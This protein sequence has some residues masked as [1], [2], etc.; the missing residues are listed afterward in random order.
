MT[1]MRI[2]WKTLLRFCQVSGFHKLAA[3]YEAKPVGDLPDTYFID[4]GAKILAVAHFD[5]VWWGKGPA[6]AKLLKDDGEVIGINSI[7]LDDRLGAY[8]ICEMLPKLGINVDVLITTDE[9]I[10]RSTAKQVKLNRKYNWICSFD[11]RGIFPVAYQYEDDLDW[12]NAL[13]SVTSLVRGSYSDIRD[14]EKTSGVCGVNWGA[15][16]QDEHSE[17]CSAF[18]SEIRYA[19]STFCTFFKKYKDQAFPFVPKVYTPGP[20][21]RIY[22]APKTAQ[23]TNEFWD[24]YYGVKRSDRSFEAH[25]WGAGRHKGSIDGEPEFTCEICWQ[26]TNAVSYLGK[27]YA[28]V[29]E[30]C[31]DEYTK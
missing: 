16:Y 17:E 21:A 19:V 29:C 1:K 9:E 25:K 18:I 23:P 12:A 4:R 30:E 28:W 24:D 22:P 27:Y 15:G 7:A 2:D 20:N 5:T 6:P 13:K 31:F 26:K 14:L 3:D 10:G 8:I 11:R